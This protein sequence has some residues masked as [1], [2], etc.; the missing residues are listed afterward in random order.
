VVND[1]TLA[2]EKIGIAARDRMDGKVVAVTGSVGKTGTKEMLL[3]VLG[4][5][6]IVSASIGNLNN[7]FGVPLSLARMA[8]ETKFGVFEVGMNH[9]NEIRPLVKMI[10]PQV[11]IITAIEA[12][13]TEFFDSVEGIAD[14]KAEIFEGF[15]AGGT[16]IINRDSSFFNRLR[17]AAIKA[18]AGNI[19]SF[20]E[21]ADSDVRLLSVKVRE[22]Y[23]SVMATINEDIV[24]YT[25]SI[26]G[27]HH[28]MNSLAVLAAVSAVDGNVQEAGKSLKK[29]KPL[30]GRGVHRVVPL[31]TGGEIVLIDE[32]YNASPASMQAAFDVVGLM[33]PSGPGRRIAVLGDMLELGDKSQ[34]LHRELSGGLSKNNFDLVFACGQHMLSLWKELP[35]SLR[36]GFSISPEKLSLVVQSGI[37]DGDVIMVKGSLGSRVGEIVK[38]ILEL[39]EGS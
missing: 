23:S 14:A 9:A 11:A 12:A 26:P 5:Q 39:E 38:S 34:Q 8:K 4:D 18:G 2:L 21:N 1:T 10:R 13:H 17:D 25:L 28:V 3:Q 29:F 7:H 15:E 6:G 32:S 20:G 24:D 37:H 19:I 33:K 27:K 16:A 30:N 36:G 22:S 31:P 35:T